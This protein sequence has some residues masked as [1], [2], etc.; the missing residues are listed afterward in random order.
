MQFEYNSHACA[1]AAG[2]QP[3]LP[4]HPVCADVLRLLHRCAHGQVH[5]AGARGSQEPVPTI[6]IPV[7]L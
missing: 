5:Q 6:P 7:F 1:G 2:R 4:L 3:C